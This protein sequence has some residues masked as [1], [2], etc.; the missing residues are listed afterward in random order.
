MSRRKH[1]LTARTCTNK[2]YIYSFR[3]DHAAKSI[4]VTIDATNILRL[5][6]VFVKLSESHDLASYARKM[7]FALEDLRRRESL[8]IVGNKPISALLI[9]RVNH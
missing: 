4:K 9:F 5:D 3:P 6:E 2:S 8:R 7:F 1:S